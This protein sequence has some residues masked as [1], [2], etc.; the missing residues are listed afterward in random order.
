MVTI[1]TLVRGISRLILLVASRPSVTGILT[2]I[3]TSSGESSRH[4]EGAYWPSLASATTRMPSTPGGMAL[5][6]SL[7]RA[8][9]STISRRAGFTRAPLASHALPAGS[10]VPTYAR[11]LGKGARSAN[12]LCLVI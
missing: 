11:A 1:T 10:T 5:R 12:W 9:S 3:R 7:T 2:S 8:W 6:P 4:K